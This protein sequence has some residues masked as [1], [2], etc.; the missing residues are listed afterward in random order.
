MKLLLPLRNESG[1]AVLM[2][3][4]VSMILLLTIPVVVLS[5]TGKL[6]VNSQ[7]RNSGYSLA[8]EGLAYAA[9]ALSTDASTWSNALSGT[10]PA[11]FDGSQVFYGSQGGAFKITCTVN[12]ALSA[13]SSAPPMQPYEVQVVAT[14][15]KPNPT[16]PYTAT[17]VSG[18]T[19]ELIRS[20]QA[21]FSQKTLAVDTQRGVHTSVAM[22]QGSGGGAPFYGGVGI[23][24]PFTV[25]W[26]GIYIT[27]TTPWNV[28][29]VM[30]SN[31]FPR[32][33]S[34]GQI[35]GSVYKRTPV[36]PASVTSDG[37]E[38][39][40]MTSFNPPP[41]VDITNYLSLAQN[42]VGISTPAN[43]GAYPVG[44]GAWYGCQGGSSVVGTGCTP[45]ITLDQNFSV[46][47]SSSVI[48]VYATMDVNNVEFDNLALDLNQGAILLP[49]LNLTLNQNIAGSGLSGLNLH[50]PLRAPQE[51]P[52]APMKG[53]WPCVGKQG[54]AGYTCP[55]T[56]AGLMPVG[57]QVNYRGFLYVG[58]NLEVKQG[59]WVLVGAVYVGG[60]ITIDAGASLTIIHDDLINE[61]IEVIDPPQ[62]QID[63][64][65][66]V[67]AQ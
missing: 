18:Q 36:L 13:A 39:W 16:G 65:Q 3:T 31:R 26:G 64:Q 51:Y 28:S 58:G 20:L 1:Q 46:P 56:T 60:Q 12:P 42:S 41:V 21:Y 6:R 59:N 29:G 52:Y 50:V 19:F 48:E 61:G 17:N 44:S 8:Q 35:I 37:N 24:N 66:E 43:A 2:A 7:Q 32:K 9:A 10:F 49:N 22:E 33:F 47:N 27:T 63:S 54:Q 4:L 45:T 38:Y 14:S 55:E 25:H 30:D 23:S 5:M 62:L 40:A 53:A 11:G 34:S 15:L 67:S 57:A